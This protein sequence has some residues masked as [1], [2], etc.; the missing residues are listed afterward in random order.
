MGGDLVPPVLDGQATFLADAVAHLPPEPWD[1][2]TWTSWTE[3][4]RTLTGRKGRTL[5][6]PLRL[7]NYRGGARAGA[8]GI[9]PVD[10]A[11]AG[12]DAAPVGC[13]VA[14]AWSSARNADLAKACRNTS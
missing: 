8:G 14:Q 2:T 10:R 3:T 11:G 7:A 5:F 9:A 13:G 6:A 4:L 1:A 12:G